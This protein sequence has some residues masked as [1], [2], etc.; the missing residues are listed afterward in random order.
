MSYISLMIFKLDKH[1]SVDNPVDIMK[2]LNF[3]IFDI[4]GDLTFDE[5]FGT[6]ETE[7]YDQWIA[8]IFGMLKFGVICNLLRAYGVP[9][10][11]F[12]DIIPVLRRGRNAHINYTK[13]KMI[14]RLEKK[15]DRKDFMRYAL[16][17]V[18]CFC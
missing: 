3:L 11:K 2:Y 8:N 13:E 12:F 14:R 16:T 1:A 18:F 5:S 6:L 17:I 4:T 7:E 9:V 15:T 10:A